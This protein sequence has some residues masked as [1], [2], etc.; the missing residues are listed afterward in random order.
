MAT[1]ELGLWE[2]VGGCPKDGTEFVAYDPVA[3]K[4]DVCTASYKT[5]KLRDGTIKNYVDIEVTQRDGEWGPSDS[6]FQPERA[7]L[8]L[9]VRKPS[10]IKTVDT[11]LT[12]QETSHD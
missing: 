1:V 3:D 8:Y 6:D 10:F 5:L 4:I 12:P 7:T 11:H 2:H 9:I